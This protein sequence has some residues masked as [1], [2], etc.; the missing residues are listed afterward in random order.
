MSRNA[1]DFL[2]FLFSMIAAGAAIGVAVEVRLV[3]ARLE[4][5]S[6]RISAMEKGGPR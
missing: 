4:E 3:Q 5:I 6:A 2:V 1:A